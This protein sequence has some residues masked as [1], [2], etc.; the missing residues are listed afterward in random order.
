MKGIDVTDE[1][2]EKLLEWSEENIPA[3]RREFVEPAL[4]KF[5]GYIPMGPY[6]EFY[7]DFDTNFQDLQNYS[8]NH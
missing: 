7:Y 8:G 3:L 4:Q 6:L 1:A 2:F 5:V